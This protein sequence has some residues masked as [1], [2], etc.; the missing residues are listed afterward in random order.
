MCFSAAVAVKGAGKAA[1]VAAVGREVK[2][3]ALGFEAEASGADD[4]LSERFSSSGTPV[5]RFACKASTIRACNVNEQ[6]DDG[7][8][9]QRGRELQSG[10]WKRNGK[11]R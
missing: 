2:A 9:M 11:L 7:A 10:W 4:C 5:Q 1:F 3:A 6:I 8:Q